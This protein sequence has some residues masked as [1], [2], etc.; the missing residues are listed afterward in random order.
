[1]DLE[2]KSGKSTGRFASGVLVVLLIGQLVLVA[3]GW[4]GD[5]ADWAMLSFWT[6]ALVAVIAVIWQRR[7]GTRS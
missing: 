6:V 3:W 4:E 1:M 7:R 5:A 2:P